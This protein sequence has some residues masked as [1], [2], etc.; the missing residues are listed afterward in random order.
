MGATQ[1]L[2]YSRQ[3]QQQQLRPVGRAGGTIAIQLMLPRGVKELSTA[4]FNEKGFDSALTE[5]REVR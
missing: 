4:W 1:S 3:L 2:A 5:I